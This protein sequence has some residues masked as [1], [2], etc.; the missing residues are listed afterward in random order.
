MANGER[1]ND[2]VFTAASWDYPLGTKVEVTRI[3]DRSRKPVLPSVRVI[4]TDRGPA[5]RLVSQGRILDLSLKAAQTL[6]P[7]PPG[8]LQDPG[9]IKVKITPLVP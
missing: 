7:F 2:Q 8:S 4:I 9:L 3:D 1:L 6:W 5:R